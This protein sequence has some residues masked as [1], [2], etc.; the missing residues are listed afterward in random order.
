LT[1]AV[2]ALETLETLNLSDCQL[3]N[4]TIKPIRNMKSVKKLILNGNP[5]LQN[6]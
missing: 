6:P 2:A 5:L 3:D 1:E 4:E